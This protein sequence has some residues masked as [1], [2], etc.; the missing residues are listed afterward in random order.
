MY[1]LE[2][3]DI[4]HIGVLSVISIVFLFVLY[5][6]NKNKIILWIIV[7]FFLVFIQNIVLYPDTETFATPLWDAWKSKYTEVDK[8][9]YKIEETLRK[10]DT[11][12]KPLQYYS[13]T[14][15][16]NK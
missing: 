3:L 10:I 16:V 11:N 8:K 14:N 6:H 1:L 7:L 5:Y 13:K 2:S 4:K 15:I 12:T 9:T